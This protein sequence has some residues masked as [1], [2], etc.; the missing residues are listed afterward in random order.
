MVAEIVMILVMVMMMTRMMIM[1]LMMMVLM[2]MVLGGDARQRRS[3]A[4]GQKMKPPIFPAEETS[5]DQI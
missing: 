1:V 2:I 5:F 4:S 3:L